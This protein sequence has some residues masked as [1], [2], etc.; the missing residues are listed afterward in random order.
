MDH[1]ENIS[2][3]KISNKSDKPKSLKYIS[4]ST[5]ALLAIKYLHDSSSKNIRPFTLPRTFFFKLIKKKMSMRQAKINDKLNS[6]TKY[7]FI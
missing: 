6:L 2:L 4:I 7:L 1:L 3:K 5:Y